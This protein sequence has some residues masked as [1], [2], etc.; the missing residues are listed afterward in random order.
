MQF[1]NRNVHARVE[2]GHIDLLDK[3]SYIEVAEDVAPRVMKYLNG[4]I[5]KGRRVRCNDA[6][7]DAKPATTGTSRPNERT[8]KAAKNRDFIGKS[9]WR[10]LMKSIELK[11]EKPDF[12][13]EGWARR[14]PKKKK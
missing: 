11:G 7:D 6:D 1:I 4:A 14:R 9:D 2:V 10:S 5:Y 8:R 3:I 13:E 12:S